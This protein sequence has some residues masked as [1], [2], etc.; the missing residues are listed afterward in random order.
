MPRYLSDFT[1]ITSTKHN[2]RH[3]QAGEVACFVTFHLR[4]SIPRKLRDQYEVERLEWLERHPEP[5]NDVAELEYYREFPAKLLK[6]MDAGYGECVLGREDSRAAAEEV[7]RKFDGVR[8]KLHAF[9]VMGNHIHV[10]FSPLGANKVVELV[11]AWKGVIAKRVNEIMGRSGSIWDD[12]Y[13]D[14]L[15][16]DAAHF[17]RVVSYIRNNDLAKAWVEDKEG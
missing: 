17:K 3:W 14:R 4:D 12:E 8:F 1:N 7:L 6:L 2:L 16:R 5:W 9:V 13:F 10:L 11:K 15:I